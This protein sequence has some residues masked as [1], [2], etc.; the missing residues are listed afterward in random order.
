MCLDQFFCSCLK[1]SDLECN[2]SARPRIGA[3]ISPCASASGRPTRRTATSGE[4][5]YESSGRGSLQGRGGS[6]ARTLD[7]PDET[8]LRIL[9]EDEAQA[10]DDA[11][12]PDPLATIYEV[13]EDAG[14]ADL[15]VNLDHYLYGLPKRR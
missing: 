12:R 11:R 2:D 6:S 1:P 9:I 14:P 13:A 8:R 5:I 4:A 10:A 7:L 15:S 3:K